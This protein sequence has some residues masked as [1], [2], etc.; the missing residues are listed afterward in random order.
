MNMVFG[1][2]VFDKPSSFYLFK[3]LYIPEEEFSEL[4]SKQWP[5][6]HKYHLSDGLYRAKVSR[7][8]GGKFDI[9]YLSVDGTWFESFETVPYKLIKKWSVKDLPSFQ[10]K[11]FDTIPDKLAKEWSVMKP[12]LLKRKRS[13]PHPTN[14]CPCGKKKGIGFPPKKQ[15]YCSECKSQ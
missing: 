7:V 13:D 2:G 4:T 9:N 14:I 11:R 5:D 8:S 12:P 15:W 1:I 3:D 10:R 6:R